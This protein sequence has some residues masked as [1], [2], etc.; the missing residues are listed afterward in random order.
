MILYQHNIEYWKA[1]QGDE[2]ATHV[3]GCQ[4]HIFNKKYPLWLLSRLKSD[5]IPCE[6]VQLKKIHQQIMKNLKMATSC[7][8][9]KL[10]RHLIQPMRGWAVGQSVPLPLATWRPGQGLI[11]H[12]F[13]SWVYQKEFEN[14]KYPL[15]PAVTSWFQRYCR[16]E[17]VELGTSRPVSV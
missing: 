5:I 9:P 1:T 11:P 13:L 2:W 3:K 16:I 17:M 15:L 6:G 4:W 7:K 12:F 14:K 8:H 10:D